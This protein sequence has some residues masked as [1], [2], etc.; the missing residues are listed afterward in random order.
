MNVEAVKPIRLLYGDGTHDLTLFERDTYEIDGFKV[1]IREEVFYLAVYPKFFIG[2]FSED[3]LRVLRE[4]PQ[5]LIDV[6]LADWRTRHPKE[7][8]NP[9]T[10]L[11]TP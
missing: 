6:M 7:V 2:D 9:W 11:P 8:L 5:E 4:I 10:H 3:A 1:R